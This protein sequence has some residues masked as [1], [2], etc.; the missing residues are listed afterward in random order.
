MK[1][2]SLKTVVITVFITFIT[3]QLAAQFT[4]GNIV[5]LQAGEGVNTLTNTGNPIILKEFSTTGTLTYSLQ[6]PTTGTNALLISGSATS[7]GV[8]SLSPD[9]KILSFGGYSA[10]LPNS[11]VLPGATAATINRGIGAVNAAGNYSLAV[12]STAYLST[13]NIRSAASDGQNNYWAGGSGQGTDY[14]GTVS[15]PAVVQ[16]T[17]INTRA[18]AIFNNQLYFS[19]QSSAGSQT[20][21]GIYAV[22]SGTPLTSGQVITNII[23]TGAGSQPEQYFFE[24]SPSPSVCYIADSRTSVGGGVQKWV[25]AAGSWSLAYTIPTSTASAGAFG[26]V[27]NFSGSNPVVY[28]T[29]VEGSNNRLVSINDVGSTSTA[30]TI[31]ASGTLTSFRGLAFSPCNTPTVTQ[32][33]WSGPACANNT[34]QLLASASGSATSYAW[35]GTGAFTATNIVN[36]IV[37]NAATSAYTVYAINACGASQ[38][39]VIN[40]SVLAVPSISAVASSTS[41]CPGQ[42]VTLS[43]QGASSYTWSPFIFNAQPFSP[44]TTNI[45]TVSATSNSCTGSATIAVQVNSFAISVNSAV[46]CPGQTVN[47]TATGAVTYT[48]NN[49]VQQA[50]NPVNPATTTV[51]T[52][53]GTSA[54]NCSAVATT[55]VIVTNSPTVTVNSGTICSGSSFTLTASGANSYTWNTGAMTHSIQVTPVIT[56]TYVV[57][58]SLTGCSGGDVKTAV[59]NVNPTPTLTISGGT[60]VCNFSPVTLIATGA[61]GY[62]WTVGSSTPATTSTIMLSPTVVTVYTLTGEQAGCFAVKIITI[63]TGKTPTV[64]TTGSSQQIC[65]GEAAKL[66]ASGAS[67]Y[68]WSTGAIGGVT[69]DT[70][71]THTTYVVTGMNVAGCTSSVALNVSVDPCTSLPEQE[72]NAI[73][74]YPSPARDEIVVDLL[75]SAPANLRIINLDGRLAKEITIDKTSTHIDIRSLS[76]GIYLLTITSTTGEE[77][78]KRFIKSSR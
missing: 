41:I 42:T 76:D 10:T 5:V 40:V 47:L 38:P 11:V 19:T 74:F 59:V 62:T 14:F 49:N 72:R 23:N 31:A 53:T 9:R 24:T 75:C 66:V 20:N 35:Y 21:L 15:A 17:K 43:G 69:F 1:T 37:T 63:S 22:G 71:V 3:Q 30:T 7:E 55:T 52:V 64:I 44:S 18:L 56:T 28:A 46:T 70:P 78:N 54:F 16:N 4:A 77:T 45:Y 60:V 13:F 39:A 51:Y 61:S 67:S 57:T 8:L 68:T 48:W 12:S 33:T 73:S 34:I 32:T 26:V 2:A 50:N 29:S 25:Y 65:A 58:G 36:P 27:A 6:V